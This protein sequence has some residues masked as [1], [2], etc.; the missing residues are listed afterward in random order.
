MSKNMKWLVMAM[1]GILTM[2]MSWSQKIV[3]LE[4]V[5]SPLQDTNPVN[6]L[7]FTAH[8]Q[9]PAGYEKETL[10]A[11]SHFPELK[12]VT[13]KFRVKRSFATLKTRPAFFSMFMPRGH[14][15]YVITISNKTTTKLIPLMFSN[16]SSEARTGVIGHELSH[17]LDFSK[18]NDW[19]CFKTAVGHLSPRYLDHFEYNTDMICIQH[20]LGKDLEAWSSYIRTTMHMVFW[21]GAGYVYKGDSKYERYMNPSTIEKN[22]PVNGKASAQINKAK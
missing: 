7:Q 21:R 20:G 8:K 4:I 14:R 17:V 3:P 5:S 22:M 11:L 19:Q 6:L 10:E 13:I 16:L 1:A 15:S 2:N 12:N 18:K 9:L